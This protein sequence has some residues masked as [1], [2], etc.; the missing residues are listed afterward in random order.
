MNANETQDFFLTCY[1]C[2]PFNFKDYKECVYYFCLN[3]KRNYSDAERLIEKISTMI[4]ENPNTGH[5]LFSQTYE[6]TSKDLFKEGDT[7]SLKR[8]SI[9]RNMMPSQTNK[10]FKEGAG[11]YQFQVNFIDM[12]ED[13]CILEIKNLAN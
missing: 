4:P 10:Y 13:K 2:R 3:T 12:N 9:Y 6:A 8:D 5:G 1:L 7:F 11:F